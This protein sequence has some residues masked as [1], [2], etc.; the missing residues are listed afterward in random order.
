MKKIKYNGKKGK[1]KII[2][3]DREP[4]DFP[5]RHMSKMGH[6]KRKDTLKK[7]KNKTKRHQKNKQETIKNQ[8]IQLKS[9]K[10]IRMACN[11]T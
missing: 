9:L 8:F 2:V 4:P 11:P 1:K 3:H 5:S 7:D 10:I 6:F